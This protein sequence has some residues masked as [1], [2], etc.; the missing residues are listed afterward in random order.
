[1]N[2]C[3][4]F[5]VR[6]TETIGNVEKR[7]SGRKDYPISSEGEKYIQ[8]LTI[9]L[10]NIKFDKIYASTSKRTFFTVEPLAKIN[11]LSIIELEDLCEMN[12]GIY[13]GLKWDEINKLNPK[14]KQLHI[15]T[16][17]IIGIK[18]QESSE[19]VASRM[20]NCIYKIAKSNL[21]NTILICSHG[22]AI[23]AFLRKISNV[24]FTQERKKYCQHNT[25][26][27]ILTFSNNQFYIKEIGNIHHLSN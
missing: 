27:N 3:N 24:E 19:A 6:H 13:D 12:F 2:C 1:M 20:Y 14:I 16:N 7:L 21:G 8:K 9:A 11:K 5:I 17:Q 15:E 18:N 22:V 10:K 23:E 26:I 4:L 25:S